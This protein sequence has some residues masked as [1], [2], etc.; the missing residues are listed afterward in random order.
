MLLANLDQVADD[1]RSGAIVVVTDA[2]L[3]IR[4]LP[5]PARALT[6]APL[7]RD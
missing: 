2:E 7:R 4:L 3:R 5:N 1:L 6:A